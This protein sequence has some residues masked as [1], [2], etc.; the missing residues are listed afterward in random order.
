VVS[1]PVPATVPAVA[2]PPTAALLVEVLLVAG[3]AAVGRLG[4]VLVSV[5]EGV[6]AAPDSG[7]V[8]VVVDGANVGSVTKP[9]PTW[10]LPDE[11]GVGPPTGGSVVVV[12]CCAAVGVTAAN[13]RRAMAPQTAFIPRQHPPRTAVPHPWPRQ[14]A[15]VRL[16]LSR[17]G[18]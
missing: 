9:E 4:F 7:A 18:T 14:E 13:N 11:P 10:P 15:S 8:L 17:T 2:A 1:A 3:G 6:V 12:V 16:A 5:P